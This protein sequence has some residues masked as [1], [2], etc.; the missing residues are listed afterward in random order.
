MADFAH[1]M[2]RPRTPAW[3]GSILF[4]LLIL[5]VVLLLL[6]LRPEPT[7]APG[8]SAVG[9]IVLKE[10]TEE[11]Q[12]YVDGQNNQVGEASSHQAEERPTAPTEETQ[13]ELLSAKFS[14]AD[15]QALLPTPAIGPQAS[16]AATGSR[17]VA[18]GAMQAERIR[19]GSKFPGVG[20]DRGGKRLS[21]FGTNGEGKTFV[22]VIDRSGSMDERGGRPMRAARAEIVRN[23][24]LLDDLNQFN[25]IFYNESYAKW[26]TGLPFASDANRESAKRHVEA[27]M[28][29]GGTKH[30]DPLREALRLGPEIIFFLT[31]G[32][33]SE[34]QLNEGELARIN[35]LNPRS[36]QINVIQFGL[37]ERRESP[38]LRRLAS[39][40]RGMYQYL[41]VAEIE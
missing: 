6:Y 38:F 4:H 1:R 7:E 21:M 35:R 41:N 2:T 31:D 19:G 17:S 20:N 29:A 14:N 26:R 30:Q 18:S 27:Q 10:A 33:E 13:A 37:G 24:D 22:F 12:I 11:G 34:L 25:L 3:I 32:D 9:G 28:A 39:E 15:M 16:A 36:I 23:I 40:N 5:T 8:E